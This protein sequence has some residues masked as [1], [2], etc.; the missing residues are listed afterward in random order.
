[1]ARTATLGF[2]GDIRAHRIIGIS[3]FDVSLGKQRVLPRFLAVAR[4][5]V[6]VGSC[7]VCF[8]GAVAGT[9]GWLKLRRWGDL[10]PPCYRE[11]CFGCARSRQLWLWAATGLEAALRCC[12]FG[13]WVVFVSTSGGQTSDGRVSLGK[14]QAHRIIGIGNST[15]RK[16]RGSTSDL[17]LLIRVF[18]DRFCATGV[19]KI[20]RMGHLD[21]KPRLN[22][23]PQT[24]N[25]EP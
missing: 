18:R 15:F 19:A 1:M 11:L 4:R 22:P 10:G 5:E 25:H 20:Q 24:V 7:F 9:L 21:Q 3:V 16:P 2:L 8:G 12:F 17:L 6:G 14:T 13:F 23:E